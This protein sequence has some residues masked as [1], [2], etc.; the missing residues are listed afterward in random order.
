MALATQGHPGGG[1]G[2]G[3]LLR[4][5]PAGGKGEQEGQKVQG[6][7]PGLGRLWVC[8]LEGVC[9][10]WSLHFRQL[11]GITITPPQTTGGLLTTQVGIS[12]W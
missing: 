8:V 4:L 2:Q 5:A 6:L 7:H 12:A 9:G 3:L 11:L 1:Q 10:L